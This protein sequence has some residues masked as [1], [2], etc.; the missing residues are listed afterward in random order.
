MV[1]SEDYDAHAHIQDLLAEQCQCAR[2]RDRLI[3]DYVVLKGQ[4]IDP[5]MPETPGRPDMSA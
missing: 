2:K 4:S 5:L 3:C 1:G